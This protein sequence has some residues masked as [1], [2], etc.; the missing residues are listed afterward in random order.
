M[1]TLATAMRAL[2]RSGGRPEWF[3]GMARFGIRLKVLLGVSV[4]E[5]RRIARPLRGDHR[6]AQQLWGTGIHDARMLACMIDDPSR[7]TS[8]QMDRWSAQFGNWAICDCACQDVFVRTRHAWAKVNAWS[9]ARDEYVRRA[10]FSLLAELAVHDPDSA[11]GVFRGR[12][13][14]IEEASDDPRPYVRKAVNWALRQIGKRNPRLRRSAVAVARRIRRRGSSSA[15]WIAADA[16]R[17]LTS[18]KVRRRVALRAAARRAR[19]RD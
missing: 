7:V 16:I 4:P 3:A 5:L 13:H 12:F 15:R 19:A 6:L 8:S 9:G 17:E 1:M 2:R 18:E 11:D 10:A 14:L